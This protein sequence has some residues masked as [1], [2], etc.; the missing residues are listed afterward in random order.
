MHISRR[1]H[2][3]LELELRVE[4]VEDHKTI[5]IFVA[6]RLD[7]DRV[8][9]AEHCCIGPNTQRQRHHSN[10]RESGRFLQDTDGITNVL[11]E[12]VHCE[13][14]AAAPAFRIPL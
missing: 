14:P 13:A 6:E 11:P 5:C 3:R 2:I 7:E 8:H 12:R 9:D 10:G 4:M 1:G